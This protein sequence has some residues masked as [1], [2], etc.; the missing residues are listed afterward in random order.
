MRSD[1]TR[2]MI[3]AYLAL[4]RLD[5]LGFSEFT[6]FIHVEDPAKMHVFLSYLFS[7]ETLNGVLKDEWCRIFDPDFVEVDLAFR[8]HN[9]NFADFTC[10]CLLFICPE[11]VDIGPVEF[12]G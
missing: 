11:Y 1:Y 5:D 2:Y 7:K 8:S 10:G 9:L 6:R 3:L 12:L 4:F